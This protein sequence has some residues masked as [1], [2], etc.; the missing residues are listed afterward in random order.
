[1]ANFKVYSSARKD[2]L[3]EWHASR[4]LRKIEALNPAFY[5]EPMAQKEGYL[6]YTNLD[7]FTGNYLTRSEF[8]TLYDIC[9]GFM[10]SENPYGDPHRY[11]ELLQ[12]SYGWLEKIV[13]LLNLHIVTFADGE[14]GCLI[15]MGGGEEVSFATFGPP[16][17][18]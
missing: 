14:E 8:E 3:S 10:H 1:M 18:K 4:F 12:Q 13:N 7:L 2:H 9:G 5:P 16:V 17:Q 15:L 6:P 11:E